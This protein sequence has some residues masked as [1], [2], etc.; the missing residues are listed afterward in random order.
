MPLVLAAAAMGTRFELVL[1]DQGG[2]NARA[3][4]EAALEEVAR[5]ESDLSRF[6]SDSFLRHLERAAARGAAAVPADLFRLLEVCREVHQASGGA[7]DVTVAPWMEAFDAEASEG[8]GARQDQVV[9]MSHLVLDPAGRTVR[10]LDPRIRLDFGAI[11]KGWALERAALVLREAGVANALLHGGTS[12][13][14][15]L[16]SPP[17]GRGWGVAVRDPRDA[18]RCLARVELRDA[19][20]SVSAP[21]GKVRR[22]SGE[23]HVLDPRSGRSAAGHALAA[24]VSRCAALADA[25]ST[26]LLVSGPSDRCPGPSLCLTDDGRLCASDP[27]VFRTV[28]GWATP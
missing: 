19:A 15:G 13:V 17:G 9:G 27:E 26:A 4:G 21:H 25:W 22:G 10:F 5:A 11:G 6:R 14:L 24:V 3:A 18:E 8:G 2:A 20:L 12:S 7:F 1:E 16:G 28:E 23:G